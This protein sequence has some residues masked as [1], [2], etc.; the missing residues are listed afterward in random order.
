VERCR[1]IL[2]LRTPPLAEA[3]AGDLL[4]LDAAA[5]PG[6]PRGSP[7]IGAGGGNVRRIG[8]CNNCFL[9]PPDWVSPA[10]TVGAA[11]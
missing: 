7:S 5:R 8:Q 9:F 10:W 6:G 3:Q 4:A 11:R 2:P 1:S